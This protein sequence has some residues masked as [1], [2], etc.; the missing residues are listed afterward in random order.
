ME[1]ADRIGAV[2]VAA[3]ARENLARACLALGD[4]ETALGHL[5]PA[6]VQ[7]RQVGNA[8]GEAAVLHLQ[9]VAHLAAGD[10]ARCEQLAAGAMTIA[11][12]TRDSA[13]EVDIYNTWGELG[14]RRGRP[15]AAADAY[16]RALHLAGVRGHRFGEVE[17]LIGLAGAQAAL[18]DPTAGLA[19]GR[20]ALSRAQRQGY[21]VLAG[22]AGAA[23]AHIYASCGRTG[24]AARH[25]ERALGRRRETGDRAGEARSLALLAQL[26]AGP[27]DHPAA[28]PFR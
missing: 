6:L 4:T 1:L 13:A 25:L 10:L 23:L 9:A 27:V 24:P 12:D 15:G 11:L 21:L 22:R 2:G 7:F 8:S 20:R 14:L 18:G 28:A 19:A 17:A 26:R 16:R 5:A 3:I